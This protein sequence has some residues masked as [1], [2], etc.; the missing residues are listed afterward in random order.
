MQH[1]KDDTGDILTGPPH[2]NTDIRTEHTG[3][4][5]SLS[6]LK[7]DARSAS[8]SDLKLDAAS[9]STSDLTTETMHNQ[10]HRASVSD[11][12]VGTE[13]P[14]RGR[15]QQPS[16]PTTTDEWHDVDVCGDI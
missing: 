7:V 13:A 2:S 10:M 11:L 15:S 8:T 4:Q 9:A 16:L 12:R 14:S 1:D 3:R 5:V 6:D